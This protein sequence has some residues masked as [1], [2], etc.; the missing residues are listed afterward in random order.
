M[1]LPARIYLIL[2]MV[3]IAAM[4]FSTYNFMDLFQSILV[5]AIWTFI[6]N[7]ICKKTSTTIA[8]VILLLPLFSVFLIGAYGKYNVRGHSYKQLLKR[9]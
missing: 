5:T 9:Y 8:W 6:L 7:L 2:A 4:F 1:C 3:S